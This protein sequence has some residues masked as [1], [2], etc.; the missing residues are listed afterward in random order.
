MPQPP[1][2]TMPASRVSEDHP[3]F[4]HRL[5]TRHAFFTVLVALVAGI[6]SSV[7]EL[8]FNVHEERARV[9]ETVRLVADMV[10]EPAAAAAYAFDDTLAQHIV[11]GV[12]AH[13]GMHL[14]AIDSD[15][16]LHMAIASR[17]LSHQRMLGRIAEHFFE[18]VRPV[19]VSLIYSSV[20]LGDIPV[21]DLHI[22]VDNGVILDNL[23]E[24]AS[25]LVL[26]SMVHAILLATAIAVLFHILTTKPLLRLAD[27][28]AEVEPDRPIRQ[29]VMAPAGH[30]KDE[31]GV[32]AR[33]ANR[34]ILAF[35]TS[36]EE[37]DRIG[38]E[39]R[40]LASDLEQRVERRTAELRQMQLSLVQA[41][42]MAS[43]G[44]LVAGVAHE[45]NTPI[46]NTLMVA[47]SLEA[48]IR[49]MTGQVGA[50]DLRRSALEK[51]LSESLQAANIMAR[52]AGRAAELVGNFKQI[53][54]D[55]SSLRRRRFDFATLVRETLSSLNNKL[56]HAPVAVEVDIPEGIELDN[57]P[58]PIEQ[59]LSNFVIN[60]LVHAFD[61]GQAGVI[62]IAARANNGQMEFSFEDNGRGMSDDTAKHAF[63]PFFTTKFGQGGSGLGLYIVY[64]LVTGALNGTMTLVTRPG[65]GTRFE[66]RFPLDAPASD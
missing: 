54:V 20:M 21:G 45:L 47:T 55:Q 25:R 38:E 7:V 39:L 24:E 64:N 51:F 35:Q 4:R 65:A 17:P 49:E 9:E 63:D 5:S 30:D 56:K 3:D 1:Q 53:A 57:H 40:Q 58:G 18:P 8:L 32:I 61:E 13:R 10:K 15:T 59:I 44:N 60:S 26:S 46:G 41:E 28:F 36:L 6:S 2:T 43:L 48:Q 19:D 31:L 34:L 16:G 12:I 37:R 33:A 50:G 52:E 66:L 62:R 42:K 22:V 11:D 27:K 29:L 14:V 23:W